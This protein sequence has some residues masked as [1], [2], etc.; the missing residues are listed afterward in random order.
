MYLV[1]SY[2]TKQI[3]NLHRRSFFRQLI[4][5]GANKIYGGI[6]SLAVSA[7]LQGNVSIDTYAHRTFVFETSLFPSADVFFLND[8]S[9][10][11]DASK[12]IL[13][14]VDELDLETELCYLWLDDDQTKYTLL[15]RKRKFDQ[16]FATHAM[17][18]KHADA[19]LE[20]YSKRHITTPPNKL[21]VRLIEKNSGICLDLASASNRLLTN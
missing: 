11:S 17:W 6:N 2:N 7:L 16:S 20:E 9:G 19:L 13:C 18:V 15:H 1:G 5:E 21:L 8:S 4:G 14:P 3:S 10:K 12:G